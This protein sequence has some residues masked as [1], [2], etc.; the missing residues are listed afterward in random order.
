MKALI[1]RNG[2]FLTGDDIADAVLHYGLVLARRQQQDV[3]DIP[4][5]DQ[6]GAVGRVQMTVGWL[7]ENIATTVPTGSEA[8]PDELLDVDATLAL[9]EKAENTGVIRAAP[10]SREE[11]AQ[12]RW[13][14]DDLR[15]C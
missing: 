14:W 9:Y 6:D 3:I 11:A 10:L 8:E 4:Y 5:L 7:A 15:T 13:E 1:N 12:Y 2:T